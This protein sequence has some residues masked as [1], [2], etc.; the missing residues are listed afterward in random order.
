M[1]CDALEA[2]CERMNGCRENFCYHRDTLLGLTEHVDTKQPLPDELFKK[3][4]AGQPSALGIPLTIDRL[5][6]SHVSR[7]FGHAAAAADVGD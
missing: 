3:I 2:R 5:R 7:C 1:R 6:S 4:L